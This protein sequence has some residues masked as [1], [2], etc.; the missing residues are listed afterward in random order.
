MLFIGMYFIFLNIVKTTEKKRVQQNIGY[1]IIFWIGLF[2]FGIAKNYG[3]DHDFGFREIIIYELSHWIFQIAASNFILYVLV[4]QFFNRKKYFLF[5]IYLVVSFYLFSVINR[6][7]IVYLVEPVFMNYPKDSLSDI[8]TDLEYL[9]YHYTFSIITG[10]FVFVSTMFMIRYRNEK[11]NTAKLLKEKAELELKALK[12]QLNPH[13]L[14]NTLNNIYALSLTN[15]EQT[16]ESIN[17]LSDILDYILYKGQRKTVLISDELLIIDDYIELEK[18]RYDERLKVRKFEKLESSNTIPPLLFLSLV[19]N[20]FKHGAG[21]TSGTVDINIWAETNREHSVLKVEN[22]CR[23]NHEVEKEGLGLKNI[24]EQLRLYFDN[25][26]ELITEKENNW[27]S[28]K[29]TIPAQ[30]D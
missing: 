4:D 27:F 7:F 30:H 20:A 28:I 24:K 9:L 8:F 16:S 11:E 10:A 2:L 12:S 13:F 26:F 18:L 29:I 17:R 25:R 23:D 5:S 3:Q 14:F 19:E 21:K 6:I 22:T 1:Q 15:S